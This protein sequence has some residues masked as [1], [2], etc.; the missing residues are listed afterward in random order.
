MSERWKLSKTVGKVK[1]YQ[2]TNTSWKPAS[3]KTRWQLAIF[4]ACAEMKSK[5]I[6][7][8]E[9]GRAEIPS[10]YCHSNYD[11]HRGIFVQ[12]KGG[13]LASGDGL[14]DSPLSKPD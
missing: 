3:L 10:S 9:N 12:R 1:G 13:R 6:E 2:T 4:G 14:A 7:E 11:S 5:R 8:E